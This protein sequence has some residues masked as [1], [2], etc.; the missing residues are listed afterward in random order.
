MTINQKNFH[1]TWKILLKVYKDFKSELVSKRIGYK[2][3]VYKDFLKQLK[4]GFIQKKGV[5]YLFVGF[6]ILSNAEKK[7]LKFF[8]SEFSSMA[9]W[10]FDRYYFNDYKQEA[11]ESFREFKEDK[12]LHSTFPKFI[13]NNFSRENSEKRKF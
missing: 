13:P 7:I 3:F 12:I 6:S 11:G 4:K 5:N 8:I 1:K 9:F 2:G 10:D